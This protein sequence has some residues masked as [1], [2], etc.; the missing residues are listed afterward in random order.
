MGKV[1][2]YLI[3]C[4]PQRTVWIIDAKRQTSVI[5]KVRFLM[6]KGYENEHLILR[7]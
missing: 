7:N 1:P 3:V 6:L 2:R 5:S 4:R